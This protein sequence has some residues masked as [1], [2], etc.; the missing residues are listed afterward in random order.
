MLTEL[1]VDRTDYRRTQVVSGNIPEP[2]ANELLVAIDKFAMTAN[3]VTY[4]ASG[5][6]F[7]YW[8]F[9]PTGEDP[10]GKVT[11]WGIGEVIE[12]RVAGIDVG[13]RLYG[14]F[15]MSSHV[16]MQPGELSERGFTDAKPHRSELPGLYNHYVRTQSEP[17]QLQGLEDQRCIFF[18]LFMTGYV[19]ADLLLDNDWFG[20][21]Q[22]VIGSASSKTGFS[23][24][25]FI[26]AAGFE[27]AIIGLTSDPN[28]AFSEALGC[29]DRVVSYGEVEK[30]ENVASAYVDIAG[31]VDVRSRLH[32]GLKE[33]AVQTLLVGATHWDQFGQSVGGE[34]LPGSEPQVFFAPAQIE[35]RDGEWGRGVM[36]G[37]AYAASI[38]LVTQLAPTLVMESHRGAEACDA[39]WQSL[40]RNQISG[41]RGV[42]V[43][44]Q[45]EA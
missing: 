11:V 3:N 13:E 23:T 30:I 34:P 42:M 7:G 14:F 45:A 17:S 1:W 32:R 12:S 31:S 29:Y 37:K 39:I 19:I 40:L 36:M 44:L 2:D 20:A 24:A 5:D 8:Q 38:E 15:P 16:V 10:W 35:K 4:A 41:Q 22:M 21:R 18:P 25:A 28:L 33:N 6:L 26:R 43:S 9:Y 27:G